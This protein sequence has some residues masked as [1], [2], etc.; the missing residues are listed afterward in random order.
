M[1]K[2]KTKL[3]VRCS[4]VQKTARRLQEYSRTADGFTIAA[5]ILHSTELIVETM[6]ELRVAIEMTG[7]R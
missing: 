2:P 5:A 4:E 3:E 1:S 7:K 6:D